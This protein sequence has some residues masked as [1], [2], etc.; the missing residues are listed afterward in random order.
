MRRILLALVAT[1]ACALLP[2]TA[3]AATLHATTSTF[4]STVAA[5][6][7]GDTV[8][9]A[10]GSY[11]NWKGVTKTSPGITIKPESGATPSMS[12]A[13]DTLGAPAWL[14][15]DGITVTGGLISG[16]THDVTIKNSTFPGYLQI[17]PGASP[18]ANNACGNCPAMDDNHIVFDNDVFNL[19]SCPS[20]SCLG[21]EGRVSF[22]YEGPNPAGVTV[23]N[24]TF[25]SG[26]AD[27]V[28]FVGSAGRGVTI[29]PGQH[30][31]QPA[32][33]QSA[34]RMSTASSSSAATARRSPA[35]TSPTSPPE[36]P[37]MTAGPPA[38][39]SATT[40]S[41]PPRYG[42]LDPLRRRQR[43]RHRAQH[44]RLPASSST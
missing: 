2:A 19:A 13:W 41:R 33:G 35:T 31:H 37:A 36:S 42:Y 40:C 10:S 7:P 30:L 24:S 11:G 43:R 25:T 39:W 38:S 28:Q 23:K 9:L 34:R 22:A 29:G 18:G 26:C 15:L 44:P 27:G 16:P 20:G 1:M 5:A 21:Y 12:L 8:L 14:T 4:A 3:G 32:A 6:Q 17:N